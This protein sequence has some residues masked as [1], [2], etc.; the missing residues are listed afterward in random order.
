MTTAAISQSAVAPSKKKALRI[1][2]V[3]AQ[4]L[5]AVAF[6][7]A[8]ATKLGT[9]IAELAKNMAWVTDMPPA[10]VR[11][12]GAAEVAGALGLVLP[13]LTRI[14]PKLTGLAGAGLATVMLLASLLHVSRGELGFLPVNFT[15]GALAAFVAWGR[16]IAA[17]IAPRG[18]R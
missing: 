5:L 14:R 15:L 18:A 3:V 8:G 17:P 6:G 13:A 4:A 1:A 10:L 2:L 7:M 12:I 9:P 11:F 16:G